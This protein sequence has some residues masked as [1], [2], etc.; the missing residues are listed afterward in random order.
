MEKRENKGCP[1]YNGGGGWPTWK[2]KT[3]QGKER[4]Y[5]ARQGKEREF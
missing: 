5:M 4:K 2:G 3:C 1:I